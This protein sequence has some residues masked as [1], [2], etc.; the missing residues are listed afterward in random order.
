MIYCWSID[1]EVQQNS[2]KQL[3]SLIVSLLDTHPSSGSIQIC[4]LL[5]FNMV[6]LQLIINNTIHVGSST[7]LSPKHAWGKWG[8]R[9]NL[10]HLK[11]NII[12]LWHQE[13]DST[14]FELQQSNATLRF[15]FT[16][17]FF[18]NVLVSK[19]FVTQKQAHT[20]NKPM[21]CMG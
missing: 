13:R 21:W 5:C 19:E 9:F 7:W 18:F 2:Y 14:P 10:N 6:K 20:K 3:S 4:I 16:R 17:H 11:P 1:C 15:C 8:Y 12:Y